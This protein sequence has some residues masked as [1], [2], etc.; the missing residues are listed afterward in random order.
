MP[1]NLENIGDNVVSDD[2]NANKATKSESVRND[3]QSHLLPV[4]NVKNVSSK[5]TLKCYSE[6]EL[7]YIVKDVGNY[8]RENIDIGAD[9]CN[10][11]K[12]PT[13]RPI[14]TNIR[15]YINTIKKGDTMNNTEINV[16]NL[17]TTTK[18]SRRGVN[19]EKLRAKGN[20]NAANNDDMKQN[21]L[22]MMF[23][24]IRTK[25]IKANVTSTMKNMK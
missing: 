21:E 18:K 2:L 9:N 16:S 5:S 1:N 25:I 11:N 22:Q 15:R 17:T 24:K 13:S 20:K 10:Y 7:N 19:S 14:Q 3:M 23:E 6:S 12:I 4:I 8:D